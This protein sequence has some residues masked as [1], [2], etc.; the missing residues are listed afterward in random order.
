MVTNMELKCLLIFLSMLF[1]L[2]LLFAN[3]I[4]IKLLK[5][6]KHCGSDNLYKYNSISGVGAHC[7]ACEKDTFFKCADGHLNDFL[8]KHYYPKGKG[9]NNADK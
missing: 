6:C 4:K 3:E 8:D 2:Y 9:Y 5:K 1:L 7:H